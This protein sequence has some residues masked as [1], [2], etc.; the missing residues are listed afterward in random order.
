MQPIQIK[1]PKFRKKKHTIYNNES[2][3]NTVTKSADSLQIIN[4]KPQ[5]WLFTAEHL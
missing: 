4:K 3:F 1:M 2:N 5:S